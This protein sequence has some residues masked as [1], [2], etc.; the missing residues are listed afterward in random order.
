MTRRKSDPLRPLTET[1]VEELEPL[2]RSQTAPA[3]EVARAKALLAVRRGLNYQDAAAAA[4]R[5]SGDAVSHLVSRFNLEGMAALRPRHGGGAKATYTA[6]R[7]ERII[8]E[9]RRTPTPEA[10]GTS[11]W[12]LTLLR[13]TLRAAPDGLPTVSTYTIWRVLH[14]AG[15]TYQRTRTW[16]STGTARRQR[17]SGIVTVTDPDAP[18]KKN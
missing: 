18:A 5:N 1:E 9:A 10:D 2:A 12:S 16:C 15:L 7:Q 14:E 3:A 8:R 13:D 4:G 11:T 6:A 17:K